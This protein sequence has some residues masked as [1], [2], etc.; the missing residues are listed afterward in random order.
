MSHEPDG[1]NDRDPAP[2]PLEDFDDLNGLG[3]R[4]G[5]DGLD[6]LTDPHELARLETEAVDPA[7]GALDTASVRELVELM[8]DADAAVPAAVS[9]VLP[10]ISAAVAAVVDRVGAGGRIVYVGAGTAGRLG[11]LDASEIPPTFGTDPELVQGHLAGGD[12]ALRRAVEGAED[13]TAAGA[14]LVERIGVGPA[15][16][17]VGIAASG[18]TPY[19]GSTAS[20]SSRASSCGSVTPSRPSRPSRPPRPLRSSKSSGGSGAGSR[21]FRPSGSHVSAR[22]PSARSAT[23][24]SRWSSGPRSSPARPASRPARRRSSSST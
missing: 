20:V 18:R 9:R 17:V 14:A 24:P 6:G 7:Y 19:V 4:D 8:N 11:V 22:L 23:T 1:R 13:D 21:S 10:E 16:G 12:A 5:L 3:G 2:E 15:D